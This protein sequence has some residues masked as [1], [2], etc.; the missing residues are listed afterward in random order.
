MANQ[1]LDETSASFG[2][3]GK[4]SNADALVQKLK[5]HW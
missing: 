2:N 1:C 3:E 5:V 4:A